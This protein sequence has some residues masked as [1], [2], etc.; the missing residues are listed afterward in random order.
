MRIRT[1]LQRLGQRTW[2]VRVKPPKKRPVTGS[3]GHSDGAF[4]EA[5]TAWYSRRDCLLGRWAITPTISDERLFL[6]GPHLRVVGVTSVQRG[7]RPEH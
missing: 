1:R 4:L 3:F 7:T 5:C 6:P 2:A